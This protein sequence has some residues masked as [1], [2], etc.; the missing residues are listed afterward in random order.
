MSRLATSTSVSTHQASLAMGYVK[1]VVSIPVDTP[2]AAIR[3]PLRAWPVTASS[4]FHPGGVLGA[5]LVK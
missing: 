3:A 4:R 2:K 5:T 1:L